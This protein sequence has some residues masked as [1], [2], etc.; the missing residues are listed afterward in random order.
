MIVFNLAAMVRRMMK[1][2][3]ATFSASSEAKALGIQLDAVANNAVTASGWG[4]CL[5]CK[6]WLGFDIASRLPWC[7][8]SGAPLVSQLRGLVPPTCEASNSHSL[9]GS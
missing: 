1:T 5:A 9:S 2:G 4:A 3:R 7:Y 8:G 6:A